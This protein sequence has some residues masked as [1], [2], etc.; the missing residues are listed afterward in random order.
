[1]II[2]KTFL[3]A[4]FISLAAISFCAEITSISFE[5]E[6]G[7]LNGTIIENV[8]YAKKTNSN[9]STVYTPTTKLSRLD[10]QLQNTPYFGLDFTTVFNEHLLFDFNIFTALSRDCGIMED[11]DWKKEDQPNHLTNYSIHTNA[12]E[13]YSNI[14]FT[15]G[16][17]L[18]INAVFP[19]SITPSFG[20][21]F[22]EFDFTG[23]SGYKMYEDDNWEKEYFSDEIV[24]EYTQSY[25]CPHLS[26]S[27]DF[28][29][30]SFFET[31]LVA[32]I[33]YIDE[34]NAYDIHEVRH[35][36]FN[37]RIKQA[38]LFDGKLQLSYKINRTHK[39][40][41]NGTINYMP[42]AYAFTYIST[43]TI[44]N[45]SENPDATNLGG[46]SR[47]MWSYGINYT[48]TFWN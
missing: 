15:I 31:K 32:G 6:F 3:A 11:Y 1:M 12:L 38:W 35:I 36:Y 25:V 13:S 30:T 46:T 33:S 23:R 27:A 39:L 43:T 29:F 44:N 41:L 47:L 21:D 16:Y 10:W 48:Y 26:I 45:F 17:I 24:I 34:Y 20:I 19:I 4:V 28:D 37:D 7:F 14:Y 8:W 9:T 42:D 40:S 18:K 22:Y 2:K 5:P